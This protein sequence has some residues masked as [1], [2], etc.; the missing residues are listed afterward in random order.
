[1]KTK[2]FLDLVTT[3]LFSSVIPSFGQDSVDKIEF[4]DCDPQLYYDALIADNN[5]TFQWNREALNMLVKSTHRNFLSLGSGGWGKDSVYA[6]LVDLDRGAEAGSVQLVYRD[7][8]INATPQANV[9]EVERLWTLNENS[10]DVSAAFTDIHH[11]RPIDM[12]VAMEKKVNSFGMCDTVAPKST[13][14]VPATEDTAWDTA[15]DEKIWQPP[16]TRRG[17]IARALLYMDLRY[18]ELTL[19]DCD[20]LEEQMGYLSQLLQWHILYPPSKNEIRRNN[21]ACSRWQGNRNP[22][23]DYPELAE[24]LHGS[25]QELAS[26]RLY[27]G[28]ANWTVELD[29]ELPIED[30]S[31]KTDATTIS[32][33]GGL[34]MLPIETDSM[35]TDTPT[36]SPTERPDPCYSIG[37]G[38]LPFFL[39][40]TMYPDEVVIL[41][42]ENIAG[43]ME[44]YLTDQAWDGADLVMAEVDEGVVVVS[45]ETCGV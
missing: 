2:P 12:K 21:R 4:L 30:D 28:C 15:Q 44:L 22:F 26:N 11:L 40:N 27:P 24:L 7:I 17:E 35:T 23:V 3:L 25:P 14:I 18:E 16:E 42:L 29:Q 20:P 34:D 19:Q 32:P 41:A 31:M 1:M 33:T 39:V 5:G 9:W 13:C 37:N 10:S 45:V 6:A 8:A 43:G 38:S 36:I